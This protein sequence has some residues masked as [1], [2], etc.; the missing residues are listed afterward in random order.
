MNQEQTQTQTLTIERELPTSRTR[1]GAHS[2]SLT[3]S[4]SGL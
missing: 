4:R 3:S 1:C 2:Q